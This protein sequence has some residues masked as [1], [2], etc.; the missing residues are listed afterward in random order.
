MNKWVYS[1]FGLLGD[2][3]R[4]NSANDSDGIAHVLCRSVKP[5][6]LVM[7]RFKFMRD[8]KLARLKKAF[9]V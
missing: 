3:F 4:L 2:V 7:A 1:W 5:D 9:R 6:R 8:G